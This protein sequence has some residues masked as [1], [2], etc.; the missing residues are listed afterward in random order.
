VAIGDLGESKPHARPG[1][2]RGMIIPRLGA[3]PL[4]GFVVWPRPKS[5]T[6]VDWE[7]SALHTGHCCCGS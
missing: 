1:G 3:L 5:G 4:Q 6:I 7:T 2:L